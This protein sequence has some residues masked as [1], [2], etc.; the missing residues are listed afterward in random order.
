MK[1]KTIGQL[2]EEGLYSSHAFLY[3]T[4]KGR[5]IFPVFLKGDGMNP[6]YKAICPYCKT[7]NLRHENWYLH[8]EYDFPLRYECM[9]CGAIGLVDDLEVI[10][11]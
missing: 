9:T 10:P 8:K 11:L 5:I 6:R 3:N 7:N 1:N 2:K 4:N